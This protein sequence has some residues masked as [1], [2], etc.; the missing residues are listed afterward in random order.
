VIFAV[1]SSADSGNG[2]GWPNGTALIS[3]YERS[4]N[5]TLQNGTAFPAIPDLN[6]FINLGLNARPTFFGC[7]SKNQTGPTPLIVY[8][9]NHPYTFFSNITT[10]TTT[11][12]NTERNQIIQ[13]GYNV[14]TM[15]NGTIEEGWSVCVGCAILS[16]SLE[17]TKTAVP[18]ACQDCF[19]RHC[20]NG[21]LDTRPAFKYEPPLGG[22][23]A[24][25]PEVG[26]KTPS[27]KA[28]KNAAE[29]RSTQTSGL[30]LL[31]LSLLVWFAM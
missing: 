25:S 30:A 1:D 14:A 10:F 31:S 5:A 27:G 12:N 7:D 2:Q 18:P 29:R 3:T 26:L 28:K 6:T 4:K 8:I 9:A 17:R 19:K 15:G 22:G 20:W 24:K 11:I 21:T 23:A 13:N 16:R